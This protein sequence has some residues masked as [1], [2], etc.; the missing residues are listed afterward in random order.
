MKSPIVSLRGFVLA[1]SAL[2][3]VG[4]CTNGVDVVP[5]KDVVTFLARNPTTRVTSLYSMRVDGSELIRRASLPTPTSNRIAITGNGQWVFFTSK[6]GTD[7]PLYCFDVATSATTQVSNGTGAFPTPSPDASR[8]AWFEMQNFQYQLAIAQPNGSN[9][10]VVVDAKSYPSSLIVQAPPAWSPSGRYIA[11]IGNDVTATGQRGGVALVVDVATGAITRHPT[12]DNVNAVQ[13][14][15]ESHLVYIQSTSAGA[16]L[17]RFQLDSS[18][19]TT[20]I[21]TLPR[22]NSPQLSVSPARTHI[23]CANPLVVITV[24]TGE[25]RTIPTTDAVVHDYMWS[26]MNDG[27][28]FGDRVDGSAASERLFRVSP[29]GVVT[30]L[31]NIDSLGSSASIVWL[32]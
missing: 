3:A 32:R 12:A 13:W 16:E 18:Q 23:V 27:F 21:A 25:T 7:L 11:V 9:R 17:R 31:P 6:S 24:A 1:L 19:Y 14:L 26:P 15:S 22:V 20:T 4:G 8:I 5:A 29:Q 2:V 30:P 10:T 28:V